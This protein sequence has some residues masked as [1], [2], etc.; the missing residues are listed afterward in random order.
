MNE[1][2]NNFSFIPSKW[3]KISGTPLEAEK[4]LYNAPS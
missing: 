4:H 2:L 1:A 3:V